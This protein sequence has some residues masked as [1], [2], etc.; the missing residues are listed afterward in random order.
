MWLKDFIT[1]GFKIFRESTAGVAPERKANQGFEVT[2]QSL[3]DGAYTTTNGG[4][5]QGWVYLN[6]AGTRN[7]GSWVQA[8]PAIY[9]MNTST[10]R[11]MKNKTQATDTD[12]ATKSL[13]SSAGNSS[14]SVR[15]AA[16]DSTGKLVPGLIVACP[17]HE[18]QEQVFFPIATADVIVSY[19]RIA[20]NAT[21]LDD[22]SEA[23]LLTYD[24]V[25]DKFTATGTAI[26]IDTAMSL[27]DVLF[28]T[29][30]NNTIFEVQQLGE[31]TRRAVT[32]D[33]YFVK[34][35]V[36]DE[37]TKIA[38]LQG[39]NT[40]LANTRVIDVKLMSSATAWTTPQQFVIKT[41]IGT[42]EKVNQLNVLLAEE[43]QGNGLVDYFKW[44][45]VQ[46]FAPLI[47]A[48]VKPILSDRITK[49]FIDGNLLANNQPISQYKAV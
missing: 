31:R 1:A 16:I 23:E 39:V 12:Y 11:P 13:S 7:L 49:I 36:V 14:S 45:R 20:W 47:A 48:P 3:T 43:W 35:C 17:N 19:A 2:D 42:Q 8:C 41:S 26:W 6:K 15:V 27:P 28:T 22:Q 40:Y 38:L 46:S 33:I 18:A 25:L 34:K 37:G 21:Y 32:R 24:P 29:A 9:D 5:E 30:G 44:C 10:V 4:D